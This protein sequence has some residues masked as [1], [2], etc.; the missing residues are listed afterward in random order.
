MGNPNPQR[1]YLD[2]QRRYDTTIKGVLERTADDIARRLRTLDTSPGVG[3]RVRAAQLRLTLKAVNEQLS[4][5]LGGQYGSIVASGVRASAEAA[6]GASQVLDDV[7]MRAVG[8]DGARILS[9]SL[10]QSAVRGLD[11]DAGRQRRELSDRVFSNYQNTRDE[12]EGLIRSAIIQGNSARELARTVFDFISP[13]TPGGA[14]Y[15]SMR[16]ARTEMNNAFHQQQIKAGDKP[17][18]KHMVWHLSGSHKKPDQCNVYADKRTFE[19]ADVPGK[20]H[21]HCLCFLTAETDSPE[22][23]LTRLADGKYDEFFED[24]G[25]V[26]NAVQPKIKIDHSHCNHERTPAGRAGCRKAGGPDGSAIVTKPPIV[27]PNPT[28]VPPVRPPVKK[29][30]SAKER[31]A[32]ASAD[33]PFVTQADKAAIDEK[34]KVAG[35]IK[36]DDVRKAL[37]VQADLMGGRVTKHLKTITAAEQD[38]MASSR[39]M[40]QYHGGVNRKFKNPDAGEL[41]ISKDVLRKDEK[42][43]TTEVRR[44][45]RQG[46]FSQTSHGVSGL[47]RTLAHEMGHFLDDVMLSNSSIGATFGIRSRVFDEIADAIGIPRPT[48]ADGFEFKDWFKRHTVALTKAVSRYG[49]TNSHELLAEIW[50]SYSRGVKLKDVLTHPVIPRVGRMLEQIAKEFGH[51]H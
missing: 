49:A 22:E 51:D 37:R 18:V 7:L 12:I 5:A 20:P 39:A 41:R 1:R 47:D 38:G 27:L 36:G 40:A 35:G 50:A 19:V 6:Q 17:W 11:V 42:V 43:L 48:P 15:A 24:Q 29:A 45:E 3:S 4:N 31:R 21:P 26:F 25:T 8:G 2:V 28:P 34:V 23:F 9:K 32:A 44:M 13:S 10:E 16:L 30:L 33:R 14:S 46:W